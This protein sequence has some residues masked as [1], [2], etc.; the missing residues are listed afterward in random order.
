MKVFSVLGF[1]PWWGTS[2]PPNVLDLDDPKLGTVGGG[3]E[4]GLQT[5]AGLAALGHDVTLYWCGVPGEWRGV[6]SYR[7][8][9]S[10]TVVIES[11]AMVA[12]SFAGRYSA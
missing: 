3:E 12:V 1:S 2:M 4:A 8:Y 9:G 11:H 7:V 5:A 6:D 10:E